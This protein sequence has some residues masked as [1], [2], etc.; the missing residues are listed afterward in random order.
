MRS[1]CFMFDVADE[2]AVPR[3]PDLDMARFSRRLFSINDKATT[4]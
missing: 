1:E 2:L 3:L 4:T